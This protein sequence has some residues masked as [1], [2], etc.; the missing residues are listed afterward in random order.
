MLTNEQL[1]KYADVILWGLF[2]SR[3]KP[4]RKYDVILLRYDHDA[5][6]LAERVFMRLIEMKMNVIP[7]SLLTPTM[8]RAYYEYSDSRLRSFVGLWDKNL[9]EAMNGNIFLS[10]PQSLTHL[11]DIDPQ[12][13]T[14]V[15]RARKKLREI[16]E[17]REEKGLVG[18]TLCTLPTRELAKQAKLSLNEYTTQ[19]VKA[20][21]LDEKD[22]VSRWKEIYTHAGE[23]KKWLTAMKINKV[24][25]ESKHCDLE[26]TIGHAR[27]FLGISGHNIPSFEI[28]TSPDWRGA[29]GKF[30]ANL[31]TYR[32]GNYVR[33]VSLYFEK[34]TIAKAEAK[35]GNEF[36]QKMISM[37]KGAN[38]IG[39]FSLT[40]KRFSRIDRFMADTLFDENFG[41]K[42]GNCHIAVGAS[43]SDTFNGKTALLTPSIKKKLGFNDSALHW[44]LVNTEDKIV[45]ATLSN[46]KTRVI[47]EKGSFT[48]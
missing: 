7:R 30:F 8:E 48:F 12:K 39:E 2:T 27:R 19:I 9:F 32:S 22:P 36:L 34:G 20:C 16:M 43:Y 5:L 3:P 1:D 18:W 45:T 35:E 14:E 25:I 37:D 44:D 10:A 17:R 33:D 6:P 29:R 28:F 40:D 38:K 11:K 24:R 26:I 42:F 4:F 31:P 47:Y 13:I 21:F 41:G 15:A 46:G 23:I